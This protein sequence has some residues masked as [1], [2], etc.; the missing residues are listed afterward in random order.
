ML[1]ALRTDSRPT[2]P[3][4]FRSQRLVALALV[5]V[6]GLLASGHFALAAAQTPARLSR[7]LA[8]HLDRS[9]SEPVDVIVSGNAAFIQRLAWKHGLAV[10]KSLK[11]GA[12]ISVTADALARLAG[13]AEVGSLSGDGEMRSQLALVTESTGASAAWAG[14]IAG[15]GAVM[16]RGVGV[17]IIDSGVD[18]HTALAGRIVASVD[19]TQTRGVGTGTDRYGHGTHVAGIVAAGAPKQDT[20]EAPVGMA[21]AAHLVSLKVLDH[22]GRGRASDV[23]EAIDWAIDH[24]QQ[25]GLRIINLSLGMAPTQSW[26]DDPVCQ[27]VE[28]AVRAGL[29]VVASAGNFGQT[30][31]G[32]MV[33]GSVTSPGISP[34]AITV[35]ALRT[36]GTVDRSDDVVAPWSSRGPTAVDRLIKPDMVAPG[37]KVVSLLA[38]GSTLA[39]AFPE[40]QVLGE[41]RNGYF[42]LSGTSQAAAVVSGAAA[43]LL[44]SRPELN[45]LQVKVLLQA[46]AEPIINAG[47]VEDGAGSIDLS[48]LAR[49]D[50]ATLAPQMLFPAGSTSSLDSIVWTDD[51][52]PILSSVLV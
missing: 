52:P 12:V 22:E 21:P 24:R 30:R 31:D 37:S 36:Q 17:A 2:S 20:G 40:R 3:G 49:G 33:L 41:G 7:D 11:S 19:F 42:E 14:E 46:S 38:P 39:K 26:R 6:L 27:A 25:Y 5:V 9:A 16:G 4:G 44:E 13:D 29:V 51:V 23:I 8:A 10:K 43:L 15:L 1:I 35:G 18:H 50:S 48:A 47:L 28:R 32:K 45:P 34:F